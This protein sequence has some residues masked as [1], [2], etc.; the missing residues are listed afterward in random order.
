[1]SALLRF[2]IENFRS[3]SERKS[4]VLKNKL[5]NKTDPSDLSYS[6][7]CA[8]YGANSSG[9]SNLIDGFSQMLYIIIN[10]V[11]VNDDE[12]LAYEPFL[13]NDKKDSPTLYEIEFILSDNHYRYGFSNTSEKIVGE[14]LFIIEKNEKETPLFIRNEDGI[15]VNEEA[16]QE[17]V[18]MEERTN[19]NR[20]FLSLVAQLGGNLSKAIIT[21]IS[22]SLNTLSGLDT[23]GY[24]MF[25]KKMLRNNSDVA[26]AMKDFFVS[27]KLGFSDVTTQVLDFDVNEIPSDFPEEL[28][29]LLITDLKGKK[30]LGLYSTHGFYNSEGVRIKELS[31]RF[32]KMESQGTQKLFEISGPVFDTL[33]R[34]SVIFIDELDAKMHPLMSQEI[35]RLFAD[36]KTNPN[37]AQLIFTTHDTNLLSSKLLSNNQVWFTEKDEQERSDLYCLNE[38][39][40]LDGSK[41][42]DNDNIEQNYIQGRY[43]AI[44]Y[45]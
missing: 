1:M 9:K 3:F 44:P 13:L 20:L 4:L 26:K 12:E 2:T 30:S 31:F 8:L 43:G 25:S 45:L 37:G 28:K 32:S 23:E 41:L 18:D 14:W 35:V 33:L 10:S 6:K 22:K 17:G 19:D 40:F 16:F 27:T 34:G 11:K 36:E 21:Y 15:G 38:I 39:K 5:E 29:Q 42:V 7:V 24:Q